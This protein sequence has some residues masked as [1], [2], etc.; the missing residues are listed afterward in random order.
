M[1][2]F[3]KGSPIREGKVGVLPGAFN[4]PT[5][6]HEALAAAARAQYGLDQV[7]F[8]VPEAFPHK[9]YEG[10]TF[11][12]RIAMLRAALA[13]DAGYAIASSDQGLFIGIARQ[14]RAMCADGVEICLICGR[15]AAQRIVGWDYGEGPSVGEQLREFQLLVASREGEYVPP[16]DCADRIHAVDLDRSVDAV[17]ATRVREESAGGAQWRRWVTPE[18]AEEI[19][20]R[21]LYGAGLHVSPPDGRSA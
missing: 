13:N 12:D 9:D 18:V 6:A 7:L 16:V 15:D 20:R 2:R 10:A 3:W 8:L 11:E 19:M 5:V 1:L 21:G 4:P 17:S 14:V